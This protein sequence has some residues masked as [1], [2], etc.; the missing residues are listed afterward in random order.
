MDAATLMLPRID[1]VVFDVIGTLVD[2]DPTWEAAAR[3]LAAA[4]GIADAGGLRERWVADLDRRMAAVVAGAEPWRPH[5]A[6]VVEAAEEAVASA[7]GAAAPDD[8]EALAMLDGEYPAWP[9]V[10]DAMAALRRDRLVAG[11]SNGD[12]DALARLANV[13]ALSWDVVLSTSA[14]GTYKPAPTAYRYAIEALRID[15]ARTLFVAAHP[16]DLRAAAEHGFRTAYIARPGAQ[17]P[18]DD[19]RFDLETGDLSGLRERLGAR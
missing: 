4:S 17:R 8:L 2:E 13:N 12:L 15:P 18:G 1:A 7:G 14:V 3:R 9:E 5:G 10:A 11:V 16:W 19:D 6:L